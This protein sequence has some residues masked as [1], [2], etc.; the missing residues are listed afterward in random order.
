MDTFRGAG[1][2][3]LRHWVPVA[4]T[5][6]PRK[7]TTGQLVNTLLTTALGV[8]L[9]LNARGN[10]FLL[11]FG[12]LMAILSLDGA[13]G[14]VRSR[15]LPDL[16]IGRREVCRRGDCRPIASLEA[17]RLAY[18]HP[19]L[20]RV[21]MLPEL[22]LLLDWGAE[23]WEV[24]LTHENWQ[25]LW[26]RL[27]DA[28]PKLPHWSR[29]PEVLRALARSVEVPYYLP[30]GVEAHSFRPLWAWAIPAL[31]F[32]AALGLIYLYPP[33]A[34]V[35]SQVTFGALAV[36]AFFTNRKL[37]RVHLE[38]RPAEPEWLHRRRERAEEVSKSDG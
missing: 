13:Q 28:R 30:P 24:P 12:V 20:F 9:A 2:K 3:G 34:R 16:L 33:A 26:E 22:R 10:H 27:M 5:G 35:P 37:S 11:V 21:D 23:T 18:R 4:F 32:L 19:Y 17:V 25:L 38:V 7:R 31:F 14:A 29:H 6:E 15:F 1:E 36:A 8:I